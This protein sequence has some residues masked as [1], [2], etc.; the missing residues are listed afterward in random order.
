MYIKINSSN[1]EPK[2]VKIV[3]ETLE[4]G[5]VIAYPTDTVYGL[6]CDIFNKKAVEKIYQIKKRTKKTPLSIMCSDFKQA[7]LY[8]KIPDYVFKLMKKNLPGP[9]TMILTAKNKTPRNFLS[10]N[11]TVG[12][13]IPDNNFCLKTTE[14][15]NR[16]IITTSLNLS[17]EKILVSPT[18]LSK[19]LTNKI[20]LIIDGGP[21]T[22]DSSTIIDFTQDQPVILR[23]G[24]GIINL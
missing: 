5:G 6:G 1:P 18:E 12:I 4:Q 8:A 13:R 20:D 17:G 10:K 3:I 22:G 9:F 21:L 23:Q 24:L 7:S 19:E 2:K 16:P 14:L 11:K 15:F